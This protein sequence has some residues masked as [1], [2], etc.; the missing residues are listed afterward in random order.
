MRR[1]T[2]E[3]YQEEL[4]TLG[5]VELIFTNYMDAE[6]KLHHVDVQIPQGG[7][8]GTIE[9]SQEGFWRYYNNGWSGLSIYD[10]VGLMQIARELRRLNDLDRDGTRQQI[11]NK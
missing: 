5:K 9:R 2:H 8:L 4:L 6:S 1:G 10:D 11:H 3:Q 7:K